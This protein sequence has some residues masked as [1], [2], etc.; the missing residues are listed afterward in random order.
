MT[1]NKCPQCGET[2]YNIQ[3]QYCNENR[4][5]PNPTET[6]IR[7]ERSRIRTALIHEGV[8]RRKEISLVKL[9]DI[10]FNKNKA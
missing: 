4:Y 7:L 1:K 2:E 10:I 3:C 8:L 9:D 5:L 6:I